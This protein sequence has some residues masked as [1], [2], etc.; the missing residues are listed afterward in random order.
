VKGSGQQGQKPQA[1]GY[2]MTEKSQTSAKEKRTG[3]KKDLV[4]TRKN[5]WGPEAGKISAVR[6][7]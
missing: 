7:Y 3:K 6:G 5:Q 4:R 1:K 2:R